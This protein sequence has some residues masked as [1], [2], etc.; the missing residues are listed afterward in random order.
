MHAAHPAARITSDL[1]R[2]NVGRP[3]PVGT[4]PAP[5]VFLRGGAAANC[6]AHPAFHRRRGCNA[7]RPTAGST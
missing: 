1:A 6:A 5:T 7:A 2:R 3:T 4:A